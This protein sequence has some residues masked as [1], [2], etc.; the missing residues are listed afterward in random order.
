MCNIK[1]RVK[2]K[3]PYYFMERII[4]KGDRILSIKE[5]AKKDDQ[6]FMI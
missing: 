6:N 1:G 2:I 4:T 5:K 3:I